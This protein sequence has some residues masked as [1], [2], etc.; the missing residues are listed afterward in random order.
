M[1]KILIILLISLPFMV[2]AQTQPPNGTFSGILYEYKNALRVDTVFLLPRTDTLGIRPS[3]LAPGAMIYRL[4]NKTF[5][6]YNGSYWVSF[7]AGINSAIDSIRLS[8]DTL[9]ARQTTGGEIAIKVTGL[10]QANIIGLTDTVAALR[11]GMKNIF[12]SNG[13]LTS[14]RILTGNNRAYRL[15]F[16]SLLQFHINTSPT[17]FAFNLQGGNASLIAGSGA[18]LNINLANTVL[19]NNVSGNYS[20]VTLASGDNIAFGATSVQ[21]NA[22]LFSSTGTVQFSK[23]LNNIAED[24]ILSTTVAGTLKL[25]AKTALRSI[26][27]ATTPIAYNSTTG[28]ITHAVSGVTAATYGSATQV[29]VTTYNATG[30]A[31]GVVNTL[32]TPAYDNVTGKPGRLLTIDKPDANSFDATYVDSLFGAFY[33]NTSASSTNYPAGNGG[34]IYYQRRG[35]PASSFTGSFHI[36]TATS[37]DEDF[38]FRK[39]TAAKTWGAWRKVL[40]EANISGLAIQNQFTGPQSA[41]AWISGTYRSEGDFRITKT[42]S[43]LI[44]ISYLLRNATNDANRGANIQLTGDAIPGMSTWVHNGT[45]WLE[46]M[47]VNANGSVLIGSTTDDGVNKLQVTGSISNTGVVTTTGLR[48]VSDISTSFMQF[49]NVSSALRAGF[50][51]ANTESGSNSGYDLSINR[52]SDA[53]SF[54]GMWLLL[55]RSTGYIKLGGSGSPVSTV[56]IGGSFSLP[57]IATTGN[58]TLTDVHYTVRVTSSSHAVTLPTAST[59]AGRIYEIINYNTGGTVT[60]SSVQVFATGTTSIPNNTCWKIQSDGTNWILLS[61]SN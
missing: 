15:T 44:N 32:I 38:Y 30:H 16:D 3:L 10:P 35:V 50:S 40:T 58:I 6:G 59:C 42:G 22:P 47:R 39:A 4:A 33:A 18:G 27:S 13:I 9:Y 19:S 1:K 54:L 24:S 55:Q 26:I 29:P 56:D 34:G 12:I 20:S 61:R 31:T 5:Y 45:S 7:S 57:I 28:A 48:T 43:D 21:A 46:R 14:D 17:G 36:W 2:N 53:G 23:Y 60:I 8:H 11:D 37:S 25:I 49:R 41:N 52:Y 51:A